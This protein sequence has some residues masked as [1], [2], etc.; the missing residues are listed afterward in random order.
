MEGPFAE[1][2]REL[3][4]TPEQDSPQELMI[5]NFVSFVKGKIATKQPKEPKQ[6]KAPKQ[7][8]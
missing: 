7:Q 1:E 4:A 2:F 6:T 3:N 8:K 5:D